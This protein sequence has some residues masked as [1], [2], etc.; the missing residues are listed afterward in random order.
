MKKKK[1]KQRIALLQ[2]K[3]E[4]LELIIKYQ[5]LRLDKLREDKAREERLNECKR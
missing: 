1:L 2:T 3:C 4:A 5:S